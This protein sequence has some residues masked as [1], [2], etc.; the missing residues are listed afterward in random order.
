MNIL[1][2]FNVNIF[3]ITNFFIFD[4]LLLSWSH[5]LFILISVIFPSEFQ[6]PCLGALLRRWRVGASLG[7][8]KARR[9]A[10]AF[11]RPELRCKLRIECSSWATPAP[12]PTR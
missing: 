1:R 7:I 5:V 12:P 2:I 10:R 11:P 6:A 4:G 3:I 9:M 8:S